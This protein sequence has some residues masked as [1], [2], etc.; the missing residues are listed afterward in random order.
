M[1]TYALVD[2]CS[3][4]LVMDAN[5]WEEE[6]IGR[7]LPDPVPMSLL[8]GYA[9]GTDCDDMDDTHAMDLASEAS[10]SWSF[11]DGCGA[12]PGGDRYRMRAV[13]KSG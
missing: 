2:I 4:C 7:P 9:L 12:G 8:E 10:F 6:L 1:S 5:G 3:D 13:L 11:C